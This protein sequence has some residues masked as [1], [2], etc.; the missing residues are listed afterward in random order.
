MQTVIV[1]DIAYE[2][3]KEEFLEFYREYV[4][5]VRDFINSRNLNSTRMNQ[6][7]Y[8]LITQLQNDYF[9]CNTYWKNLTK[10]Q[11]F[12][13]INFVEETIQND[14]GECFNGE[15]PVSMLEYFNTVYQKKVII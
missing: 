6:K 13:V 14:F 2:L 9:I 7:V 12:N 1:E 3:T 11:T 8:T 4:R 5:Y 15:T 10:E